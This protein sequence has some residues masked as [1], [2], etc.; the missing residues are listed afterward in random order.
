MKKMWVSSEYEKPNRELIERVNKSRSTTVDKMPIF[1][2]N[3]LN[4]EARLLQFGAT[5]DIG[6]GLGA[7]FL[8]KRRQS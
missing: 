7:A 3:D 1:P 6:P 5:M 4:S 8:S 2:I